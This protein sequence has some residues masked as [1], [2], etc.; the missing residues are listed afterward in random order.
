MSITFRPATRENVGLFIGLA[1]PTGS[2]KTFSAMRLAQGIVGR[3][4]MFAV[5]DTENRRALHYAPPPG[6]EPDFK[7]NFRFYHEQLDPPF[8]P[9][10]YAEAVLKLDEAG[11]KAIVVDSASHEHAGEG[12]LLEWHERELQRMAGNDWKR[13][14]ACSMAAW[15]SPKEAHKAMVGKLL[16]TRA[17][18]IF[19]FRAEEKIEMMRGDDGKIKIIPKR[20]RIGTD[21][22][23]PICEKSL[24]FE[25]TCSF[26]VLPEAPGVPKP[27]KLQEQ[28]RALFPLDKPIDEATGAAIAAWADGGAPRPEPK[29]GLLAA[30][31]ANAAGGTEMMREWWNS[32]PPDDKR[33]LKP[34]LD[35]LRKTAAEADATAK[36]QTPEPVNDEPPF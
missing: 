18:L 30:A 31:E 27:I 15:V 14:E 32:L 36:E 17:H 33:K 23:I 24:P 16:R 22:W 35:A 9:D 21:G 10:A 4:N 25:M 26:L 1:G 28:H 34:H 19:C 3:N 11:F 13:R 8:L 12:G 29:D 5:I 6:K 2:G 7:T 20:S